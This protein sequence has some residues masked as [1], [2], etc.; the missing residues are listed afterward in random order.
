MKLRD[1]KEKSA[2]LVKELRQLN[3]SPDGGGGDLSENQAKRFD[4]VKKELEAIEKKIERAELVDEFDRRSQGQPIGSGD[5]KFDDLTEGFSLLRAIAH[6]AGVKN[7][8]ASREIEIGQ[9]IRRRNPGQNFK[10]MPVPLSIFQR[11]LRPHE[12]ERFEQRA[13]TTTTPA[14]GPGANIIGEDHRGDRFLDILRPH[15]VTGQLGAPLLRGLVADTAFSALGTSAATGW[16]GEDESLTPSDH[17]F[18]QVLLK[19]KTVGVLTEFSHLMVIQ[20]SPDV[21]QL[22][23]NDFAASL[24]RE[25]DRAALFGGGA[26]E[27]SGILNVI[28]LGLHSIAGPTWDEVFALIN[29]VEEA[30]ATVTGFAIRPTVK[31]ALR[32]AP[33]TS[34]GGDGFIQMDDKSLAGY[35]AVSST[36]VGD[37]S[38]ICGDW[39]QLLIGM[40]GGGVDILVNPYADSVYN[41]GAIQVRGLLSADVGIR[42]EE[43]FAAA[44]DGPSSPVGPSV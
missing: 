11:R 42:H 41:K 13:V 26:N 7:V 31:N 32:T 14:G 9:E 43:A 15:M 25:L 40:W 44:I 27:P 3:D 24:A 28:D 17:A 21:E 19:P 10:G 39:S 34:G 29:A 37:G 8:D 33:R 20:S 22:A 38:I 6:D 35:R 23:R 30:N 12:S 5:H 16:I 36:L 4:V 2:S 18:K 1:L